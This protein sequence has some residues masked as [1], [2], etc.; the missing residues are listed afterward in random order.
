MCSL[1][2]N[3]ISESDFP[4]HFL[5]LLNQQ[6]SFGAD[7]IVHLDSLFFGAGGLFL[8]EIHFQFGIHVQIVKGIVKAEKKNLP[9]EICPVPECPQ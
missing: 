7:D 4:A 3:I 2:N 9:Q 6:F 8:L 1:G 5:E